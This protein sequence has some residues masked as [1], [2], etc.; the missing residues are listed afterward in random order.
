[1]L[2]R[3]DKKF[4]SKFKTGPKLSIVATDYT[5]F[6]RLSDSL[7]MTEEKVERLMR[8]NYDMKVLLE[9]Q[10]QL[11]NKFLPILNDLERKHNPFG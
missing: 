7:A 1:M 10:C 4:K 5:E 11:L 6:T 8:D 3:R 2:R 9:K